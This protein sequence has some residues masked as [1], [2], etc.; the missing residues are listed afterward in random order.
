MEKTA[1]RNEQ[2]GC[3]LDEEFAEQLSKIIN[4]TSNSITDISSETQTIISMTPRNGYDK[5]IDLICSAEDM[6]TQEK[7]EAINLAE[8]KYANDLTRSAETC[9]DIML[10]KAGMFTIIFVG[11]A[12][13]IS[14]PEGKKLF[15]T[16]SN[17]FY[18][19]I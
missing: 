13:A 2:N 8:N 19:N 12:I 1:Y 14:S 9:K 18:I 7:I 11:V 17:K 15:K 3:L 5:K 16:L 6:S 4:E 10:A